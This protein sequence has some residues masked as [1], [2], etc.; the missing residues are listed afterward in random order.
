MPT[1]VCWPVAMTYGASAPVGH[2]RRAERQVRAIAKGDPM[3]GQGL[4]A[5]LHR[6]R[7]TGQCGFIDAQ[8]DRLKQARIG[9]DDITR[10]QYDDI[11]RH[12]V[13]ARH[14]VGCTVAYDRG[15]RRRHPPQGLQR[16]FCATLLDEPEHDREER[17]HR[18]RHG[19]RDMAKDE[20]QTNRH[21]EDQD[22][23]VLALCQKRLPRWYP[24]CSREFVR[25]CNG[26]TSGGFRTREPS[27]RIRAEMRHHGCRWQ[28]V[29]GLIERL[30]CQE[31][32]RAP[33]DVLRQR[34]CP[35]HGL[36]I[37]TPAATGITWTPLHAR[38]QVYEGFP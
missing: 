12:D 37:Q 28:G 15:V 11:P 6:R 9:G 8:V 7:L 5:L 23:H 17:N 10:F 14:F 33:H 30:R 35:A 19:L 18:D 2:R 20:R 34:S 1:S 27:D 13:A 31:S 36:P 3:L 21:E 32:H 24:C 22:Q 16:P 4:H 29:R 26:Q 38:R 25:S